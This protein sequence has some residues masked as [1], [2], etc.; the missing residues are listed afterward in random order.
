MFVIFPSV[1]QIPV[2]ADLPVGENLIDH[3]FVDVPFLVDGPISISPEKITS[4]QASMEYEVFG[5]GNIIIA[6]EQNSI[7]FSFPGYYNEI[8]CL[9]IYLSSVGLK[10]TTGVQ[11]FGFKRAPSQDKNDPR[12]YL[13]LVLFAMLLGGDS[14]N[15][16]AVANAFG[17]DQKVK[18]SIPSANI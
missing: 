8:R 4:W 3:I 14:H 12:P 13:Q 9:D 2:V 16:E 17:F 18:I 7:S 15:F 10:S 11:G 6:S 1:F 5:T